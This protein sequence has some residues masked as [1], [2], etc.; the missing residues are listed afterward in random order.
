MI[1]P[2]YMSFPEFLRQNRFMSTY[3]GAN[4]PWQL[5][6]FYGSPSMQDHTV[7]GI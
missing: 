3:D 5:G 4:T 6:E 1:S 2:T 7:Y